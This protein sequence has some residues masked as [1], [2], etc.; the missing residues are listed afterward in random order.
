MTY[1]SFHLQRTVQFIAIVFFLP[2]PAFPCRTSNELAKMGVKTNENE[3]HL[4]RTSEKIKKKKWKSL[5]MEMDE[6]EWNY[7]FISFCP[8]SESI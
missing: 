5:P 4:K 8:I 7:A 2:R 6:I 1:T 3:T